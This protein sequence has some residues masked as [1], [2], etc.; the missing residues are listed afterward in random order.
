MYYFDNEYLKQYLAM[1][2]PVKVTVNYEVLTLT[3]PADV[4]NP[5]R[6]VGYDANGEASEF[7]YQA[8][9]KISV[10]K[11][12]I[13]IEMLQKIM[14]DEDTPAPETDKPAPK[15]KPDE[16]PPPTDQEE[17][18]PGEEET[19]PEEDGPTQKRKPETASYDPYLLGRD[20]LHEYRK[21]R[22]RLHL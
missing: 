1:G 6:G 17:P 22:N 20:I 7:D 9:E 21:Q 14:A 16:E 18:P 10:G 8:I 2:K 15:S 5:K 11:N 19:P 13:D 4:K 12:I 3:E